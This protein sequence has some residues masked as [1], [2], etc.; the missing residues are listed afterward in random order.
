MNGRN[1]L[2]GKGVPTQENSFQEKYPEPLAS[3]SSSQRTGKSKSGDSDNTKLIIKQRD[4]LLRFQNLPTHLRIQPKRL[5]VKRYSDEVNGIQ[6]GRSGCSTLPEGLQSSLPTVYFPTE[7][8]D[9]L[10]PQACE[11]GSTSISSNMKA[12]QKFKR[13]A[14]V[15]FR[16]LEEKEKQQRVGAEKDSELPRNRK[17]SIVSEVSEDLDGDYGVNYYDSDVDVL[18]GDEDDSVPFYE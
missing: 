17:L 16:R 4:I 12:F 14:A 13:K 2:D 6:G 3:I 8:R 15:D 18:E 7:L 11:N 1:F 9:M 10:V 5:D